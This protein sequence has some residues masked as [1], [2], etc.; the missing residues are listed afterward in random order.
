MK[1]AIDDFIADTTAG[2][3][4]VGLFY[5]SG[6]GLQV[7]DQNYLVPLGFE[8]IIAPTEG[9]LV[10]VQSVIDRMSNCKTRLIFS[11]PVAAAPGRGLWRTKS[12]RR[13]RSRNPRWKASH[14]KSA[15]SPNPLAACRTE[16]SLDWVSERFPTVLYVSHMYM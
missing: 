2:P 10:Q 3:C 14:S 8:Q 4:E 1:T 7:D 15:E 16:F 12:P 9:D 6:H 11:T 5:Y 13:N